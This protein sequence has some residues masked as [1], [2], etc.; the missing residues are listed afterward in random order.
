VLNEKMN[1]EHCIIEIIYMYYIFRLK[2]S[3]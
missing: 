3:V 1:I 2:C